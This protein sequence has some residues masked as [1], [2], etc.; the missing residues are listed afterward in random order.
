MWIN[1]CDGHAGVD[2]DVVAGVDVGEQL[3]GDFAAGA[4]GV[5]E[6]HAILD[7]HDFSG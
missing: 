7:A 2:H 4:G 6:R 3:G 1:L 5:D